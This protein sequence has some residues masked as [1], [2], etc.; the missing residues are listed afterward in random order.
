MLWRVGLAFK[1]CRILLLLVNEI[2][3]DADL[4]I[5]IQFSL[6]LV[7]YCN[8]MLYQQQIKLPNY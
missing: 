6:L 8:L 5:V 7:K 1:L 2:G 3:M 4:S